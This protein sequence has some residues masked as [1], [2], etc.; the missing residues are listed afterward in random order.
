VSR[1][2]QFQVDGQWF[3]IFAEDEGTLAAAQREAH[4]RE[5]KAREAWKFRCPVCG[6]LGALRPGNDRYHPEVCPG[7]DGAA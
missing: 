3:P 1:G 4:L 2:P 7:R 6:E 5:A